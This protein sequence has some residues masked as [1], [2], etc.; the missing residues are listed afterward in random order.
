MKTDDKNLLLQQPKKKKKATPLCPWNLAFFGFKC[1]V[2]NLCLQGLG[3]G[4]VVSVT[5]WTSYII[6]KIGA[7]PSILVCSKASTCSKVRR[8]A[9]LREVH[10]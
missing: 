9:G 1:A 5:N 10:S 4:T 6:V 3:L 7:G 8:H 2:G